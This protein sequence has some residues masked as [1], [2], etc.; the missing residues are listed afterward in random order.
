M[1]TKFDDRIV[2]NLNRQ[3]SFERNADRLEKVG[4]GLQVT[5]GILSGCGCLI[6]L[7]ILLMLLLSIAGLFV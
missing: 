2:K 1:R 3:A 6:M 5:G 7:T 4:N